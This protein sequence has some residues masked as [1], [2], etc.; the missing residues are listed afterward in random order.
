[1]AVRPAIRRSTQT[2]SIECPASLL[3]QNQQAGGTGGVQG[4]AWREVEVV[5]LKL[6]LVSWCGGVGVMHVAGAAFA[7]LCSHAGTSNDQRRAVAMG[8]LIPGPQTR[9]V[10]RAMEVHIRGASGFF[11]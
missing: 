5:V 3:V 11:V 7:A 6:P 1:M 8:S 10:Q 9:R 4:A 2:C